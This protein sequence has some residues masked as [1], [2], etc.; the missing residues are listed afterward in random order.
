MRFVI[1][2]VATVVG[3]ILGGVLM[4]A[5]DPEGRIFPLIGL[6]ML[7]LS[8]IAAAAYTA[9]MNRKPV[10]WNFNRNEIEIKFRNKEYLQ[11]Y[12]EWCEQMD[13]RVEDV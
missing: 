11:V 8:P 7:V 6:A 9:I 2:A 4:G 3:F 5:G 10:V 1:A 13:L 12:R